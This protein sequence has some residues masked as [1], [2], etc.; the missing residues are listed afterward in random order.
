[1]DQI[2]VDGAQTA[3]APDVPRDAPTSVGTSS[4]S[5]SGPMRDARRVFV[6]V[7]LATIA[8]AGLLAWVVRDAADQR[9][10]RRVDRALNAAMESMNS[11]VYATIA[12]GASVSTIPF[13]NARREF[14]STKSALVDVGAIYTVGVRGD[15][16]VLLVDS[17]GRAQ[18]TDP[19]IEQAIRTALAES[20]VV[21]AE[22]RARPDGSV[23]SAFQP[24]HGAGPGQAGVVGVDFRFDPFEDGRRSSTLI[25]GCGALFALLSAS[26]AAW[27]TYRSKFAEAER[28][29]DLSQR[30]A[31]LKSRAYDGRSASD[32]AGSMLATMSHELRTPLTAILG[33]T[34]LL[35]DPSDDITVLR[36]HAQTIRRNCQHLLHVLNDVLDISRIDAGMIR[37]DR[38]S[39]DPSLVVREIVDLLEPRAIE[40]RIR[41]ELQRA[42][43]VPNLVALDVFRVRQ[44]LLNLVGNGVKFTEEGGVSVKLS[45]DAD[46]R[47]I[48]FEVVDSGPG[49]EPAHMESLFTPFHRAD[50]GAG[51]RFKGTGLGLAISKRL[52]QRMGGDIWVQSRVGYGSR[53]TL[54]I[55]AEV[56][57]PREPVSVVGA[58]E[59]LE[60]WVPSP[61]WRI[62]VVEDTLEHQ[63]LIYSC[64]RR[65][66]HSVEVCDN[67]ERAVHRVRESEYLRE[68]YTIVL[69]DL[70]LPGNDGL[71]TTALMRQHGY[72]G[73]ILAV[74][75]DS[76][77]ETR[78]RCLAAGCDDV[79]VKPI[80]RASLLT[81]LSALVRGAP[82]AGAA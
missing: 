68:P 31:E 27:F 78:E 6:V 57:E 10:R 1:M 37:I 12:S 81:L 80:E 69:L 8:F 42:P 33:F 82:S 52:A 53:F 71:T 26:L 18:L 76:T 40:K 70:Y 14:G 34:D 22:T 19:S 9:S 55:P 5:P 16:L 39:C 46:R 28:M 25:L 48:E 61:S 30:I 13:D 73:P 64:L 36:S 35:L 54:R 3:A 44:I 47:E 51:R 65:S 59:D 62:L 32:Q 23:V 29:A 24:V 45:Y 74:T 66:G 20:S 49:I 41:L 79:Y 15:D 2:P 75:A 7:V 50:G 60:N 38:K 21:V 58:R 43:N 11:D 72:R 4:L 77:P 17:E 67:G 56:A 63:K